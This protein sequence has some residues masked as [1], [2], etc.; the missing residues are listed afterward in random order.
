MATA[1]GGQKGSWLGHIK[2][3]SPMTI[4]AGGKSPKATSMPSVGS[5]AK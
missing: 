2:G 3:T 1:T 5:K 4:K